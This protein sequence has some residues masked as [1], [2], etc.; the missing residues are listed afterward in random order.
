MKDWSG[1]QILIIGAARQGTALA[2]YLASHGA[3]VVLNDQRSSD[4]LRDVQTNLSDL[5]IEWVLDGASTLF[6]G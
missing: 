2:R 3:Q 6:A 5:P 1:Q 4:Q